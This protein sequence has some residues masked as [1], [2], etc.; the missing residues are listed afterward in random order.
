MSMRSTI[1]RSAVVAAFAL[2]MTGVAAAPAAATAAPVSGTDTPAG[3]VLTRDM[4]QRAGLAE[5]DSYRLAFSHSSKCLDIPNSSPVMGASAVQWQCSTEPNQT[6]TFAWKPN[7]YEFQLRVAHSQMCLDLV[8]ISQANG[9]AFGQWECNGGSNQTFRAYDS[10][11]GGWF[12][13]VQHSRKC[14]DVVGFAP[15]N[16]ATVGQ[17]DCDPAG[18]AANQRI[19]WI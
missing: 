5:A 6:W 3:T 14:I 10:G 9:A 7:G 4:V 11:V 15:G 12:F 2:A 18:T 13:Q 8:G 17:W 1:R 16:G 19:M